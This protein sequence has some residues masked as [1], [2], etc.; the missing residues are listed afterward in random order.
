M[1]GLWLTPLAML[2]GWS[3][4]L[5][6]T[7][8]WA[9]PR[10]T[11]ATPAPLSFSSTGTQSLDGLR[12]SS[13][14]CYHSFSCSS[15]GIQQRQ[16]LAPA[17]MCELLFFQVKHSAVE[18]LSGQWRYCHRGDA[19]CGRIQGGRGRGIQGQG[20]STRLEVQRL[21]RDPHVC[22]LHGQLRVN[23]LLLQPLCTLR[24]PV[25]RSGLPGWEDDDILIA[26]FSLSNMLC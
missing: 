9:C 3:G 10:P 13:S 12:S 19:R 1:P 22:H 16:V 26:S 25:P 5:L 4:H 6:A 18:P 7:F 14:L 2:A 17:L 8:S 24:W 15:F 21:F 11:V 23:V 20:R